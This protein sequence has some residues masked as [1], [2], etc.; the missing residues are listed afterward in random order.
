ML[1]RSRVFAGLVC[2]AVLFA[3]AACQALPA[4]GARPTA[5]ARPTALG[6]TTGSE[7]DNVVWARIPYCGCVD[8]LVTDNVSAALKRAQLAGTVKLLNPTGGWMYFEVAF[9]PDTASRDQIAA[10]IKAGG[11]Q[12]LAGPP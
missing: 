9:D 12:V 8:G 6:A 2:A 1:S 4:G 10:A 11:G 3:A 7:L 5:V